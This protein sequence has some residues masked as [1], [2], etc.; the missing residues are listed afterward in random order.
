[1]PNTHAG[2]SSIGWGALGR[3]G[4]VRARAAKVKLTTDQTIVA[5]LDRFEQSLSRL[6]EDATADSKPSGE[7]LKAVLRRMEA[8]ESFLQGFGQDG[9]R[10]TNQI[11]R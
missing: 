8:V 7:T 6:M 10:L 3:V 4:V 2:S 5:R 9:G 11:T 1:M